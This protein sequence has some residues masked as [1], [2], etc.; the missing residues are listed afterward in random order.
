MET[1]RRCRFCG[2]ALAD[3][4]PNDWHRACVD[5]PVDDG[6]PEGDHAHPMYGPR[7]IAYYQNS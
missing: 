1:R 3:D 5:A 2:L 7:L 6:P 4:A